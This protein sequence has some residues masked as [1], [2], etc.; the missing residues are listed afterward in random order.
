MLSGWAVQVAAFGEKQKALALQEKLLASN[1]SAFTEKS[2]KNGKV[3]YRV[4]IGPELKR[5]NAGKSY[6]I[7]LKTEHG[8]KGS[9]CYQSSIESNIRVII[10][11][12]FLPD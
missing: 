7:K 5:E 8:L 4:K 1:L 10:Y 12:H 11:V 3:L 2:D 9:F 6:A